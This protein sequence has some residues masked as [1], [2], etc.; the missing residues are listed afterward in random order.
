MPLIIEVTGVVN[1]EE[2][3][4]TADLQMPEISDLTINQGVVPY[5]I[6]LAGASNGSCRFAY[7]LL[8]SD[9]KVAD[10]GLFGIT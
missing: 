1:Q 9:L 2:K 7:E 3:L 8:D 5:F 10:P 6:D 4:C